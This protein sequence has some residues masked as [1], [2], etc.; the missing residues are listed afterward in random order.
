MKDGLP[1]PSRA[2]L[3]TE[4]GLTQLLLRAA[5]FSDSGTYT[6]ELGDGL[7]KRETF[8]FQV[9]ITGNSLSAVHTNPPG[10]PSQSRLGHGGSE[11]S[12]GRG[13]EV[14]SGHALSWSPVWAAR[15]GGILPLCPPR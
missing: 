7:G 6:L 14:K 8:S 10:T 4:D 1:L 12:P 11:S 2:V 9:Q 3:S 5:E 13:L 15:E